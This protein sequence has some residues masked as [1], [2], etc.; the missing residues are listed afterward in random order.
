M[1]EEGEEMK[2][3]EEKE[4]D[5]SNDKVEVDHMFLSRQPS[6]ESLSVDRCMQDS[7]PD[8]TYQAAVISP[9]PHPLLL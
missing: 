3:R 8:L 2:Q 1:I 5:G 4:K 9:T 7:Y 6:K